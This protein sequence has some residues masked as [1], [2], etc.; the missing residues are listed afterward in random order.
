M[1]IEKL[2]QI[3]NSIP[4]GIKEKRKRYTI[5]ACALD[6]K[7]KVLSIKTNNY[8]CS[9]PKQKYFADLVG[10]PEAIYLH[11]EIA[12]LIS[13]KKEVHKLMIARVDAYGNPVPAKPCPIC[14]KAI[15]EYGVKIIEYT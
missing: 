2:V 10:R 3:L 4:K 11:A 5:I 8:R 13:A 6:K 12:S 14:Q 1:K 15:E 9:H 7:G